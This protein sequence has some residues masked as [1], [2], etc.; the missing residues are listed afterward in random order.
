MATKKP[1]QL[2]VDIMTVT[3]ESMEF[4]LL[5]KTP[6]ILNAMSAKVRQELLFP[7]GKKSAAEKAS[8]LKHDPIQEFRDSIY[9]FRDAEVPPTLIGVLPT[10]FKNG[11]RCAAV[12]LPGS[13]KAQIGRLVYV[14][15][16]LTPIYGIP[17]LMMC[18]TRSADIN[19]TPD[20]RTRAVIPHWACRLVVTYTTP[21]IKRPSVVN[22]LA[23]AGLMQGLGDWR[24]EKGKG[25][26]GMYEIV[27]AD[28]PDFLSI[29]EHG[30]RAAQIEAMENPETFDNETDTLLS[31]FK[32]ESKRR[33]FKIVA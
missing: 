15:G 23:A 9:R 26:Y 16:T 10:A 30:G 32:V 13:S 4:C 1:E 31:W 12:D 33:G 27:D 14:T 8:T 6:L 24:P 11:M 7:K 20:V 22:L 25:D 2:A 5:G 17:Q 19:R 29:I 21:L 3:R 28:N 18:V